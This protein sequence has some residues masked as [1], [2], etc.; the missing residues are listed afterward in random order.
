MMTVLVGS[1]QND[2]NRWDSIWLAGE[3]DTEPGTAFDKIVSRE[4]E[5]DI[6]RETKD[7]LAFKEFKP[8]APAHIVLIPKNRNGL[9][10]LQKATP[11]H[12]EIL[13]NL[14]LVA[15]DIA[16]DETLGFGPKG[17]RIVID[18]GPLAG[19]NMAHLSVHIMGGRSMIWPPG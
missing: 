15:G 17:A 3:R 19:Q 14:L 7:I 18:D 16:K 2:R 6:V 5:A 4:M 1:W 10:R 13:G 11:E 12:A 8:A 9:T